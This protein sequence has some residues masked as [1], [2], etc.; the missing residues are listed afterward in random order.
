MTTETTEAPKKQ[1]LGDKSLNAPTQTPEASEAKENAAAD[2]Q[3]IAASLFDGDDESAD[4]EKST[5]KAEEA[6]PD[7]ED[8]TEEAEKAEDGAPD[9]YDDFD[10]GEGIELDK[11]VLKSFGDAA[12]ALNLSQEKAQGFLDTMLPAMVAAEKE[13]L[14]QWDRDSIAD[15]EIGGDKH[16]EAVGIGKKALKAFGS[17]GLNNLLR[18]TGLHRHVEIKRLLHKVGLAISEDKHEGEGVPDSRNVGEM[19]R[20]QM[21]DVLFDNT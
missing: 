4:A 20:S 12:K 17:E 8:S 6:K 18:E 11:G 21:A 16:D 10:T 1:T 15:E 14:A 13:R 3:E 9:K 7:T 5:D 2:E 19:T